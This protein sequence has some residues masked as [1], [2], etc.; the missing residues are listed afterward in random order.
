MC[1]EDSRN[2]ATHEPSGTIV[3]IT[4]KSRPLTRPAPTKKERMGALG[5][6]AKNHID[7]S[8]LAESSPT[9]KSSRPFQPDQGNSIIITRKASAPKSKRQRGFS[10][11]F[12]HPKPKPRKHATTVRFWI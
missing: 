10:D 2:L 12:K 7:R 8:E 6:L 9:T 5:G 4:S 3:A 11:A 1:G